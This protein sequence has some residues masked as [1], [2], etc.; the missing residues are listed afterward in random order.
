M[1]YRHTLPNGVTVLAELDAEAHSVAVGYFVRCGRRD[2]PEELAG[3]SHFL[4]HMAFKGDERYSA[5]DVNRVFDEIGAKYNAYTSH[6]Q[7]VYYAA[8]LPEHLPIAVDLLSTLTRPILRDEEFELEKQVILEEIGMHDDQPGSVAYDALNE[9]HFAGHP[10]AGSILGSN[11][12]VGGLT[13][14]AMRDYHATRYVGSNLILAVCGNADWDAVLKLAEEHASR[15][16]SGETDRPLP[17]PA[18]RPT[19]RAIHKP[20]NAQETVML[21][22]NAPSNASPL[23]HAAELLSVIVGDD[24]G[25]RLF[26]ELVDPGRCEACELSYTDFAGAGIYLTYLSCD[27][28]RAAENVAAVREV[29]DAVNARGITAEELEQAKN[30]V[31]S[32]IVLRSER[33]MGRLGS[34]G[35]NW[36]DRGEYKTVEDDLADLRRLTVH[37]LRDLLTK[38]PLEIVTT[39]GVGPLDTLEA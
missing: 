2:E 22:G 19:A 9:A 35:G 30:K 26:W 18:P 23:R 10:L 5:E 37:D 31:A 33:P 15:A 3:V 39:V 21:A 36:Q 12:S 8:V 16:P 7:T 20:E 34:L 29:F 17:E 14:E 24:T 11:E 1:F 32:R 27:P 13:I 38:Y 4:E 6:E 28:D 25:S